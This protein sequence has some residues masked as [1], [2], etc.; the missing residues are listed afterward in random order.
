MGGKVRKHF[1]LPTVIEGLAGDV[2]KKVPLESGCEGVFCDNY[3]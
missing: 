3:I 2:D 1:V